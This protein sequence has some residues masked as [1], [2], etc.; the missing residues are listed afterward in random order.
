MPSATSGV[1]VAKLPKVSDVPM[2]EFLPEQQDEDINKVPWYK[3]NLELMDHFDT[4]I[5]SGAKKGH[6]PPILINNLELIDFPANIPEWA[7]AAQLLFLKEVVFLALPS[8]LTVVKLTTDPRIPA[9]YDGLVATVVVDKGKQWAVPTIDDDSD[10][11][12]SQSEEEE[13][14]KEGCIPNGLEVKVWGLL[15]VE[16]L[17]SCFCGALGPCCYYSYLTNTVFIRTNTN[18]V[19]AFK[20][21]S[22]Q[23]A[24]ILGTKVY[25]FAHQGFPGTLYELEQLY[26]YYANLHV[27]RHDRIVAYMLLSKLKDFTQHC[28]MLLHNCTMTLLCLDPSYW[29]LINPMQGPEDLLFTEKCHIPSRFLCVK[30]DGATALHMTRT[31]DL[32]MLFDLKQLAQ[33]FVY[34]MHW[35]TLFGFVLCRALCANSTGKTTLVQWLALVMVHPGLYCEAIDAFNKVYKEQFV[36][37]HGANVTIQQVHVPDDKFYHPTMSLDI[38]CKVDNERLEHLQLYRTL[39]AIPHWDGWGEINKED[40]YCLMFKHAE[41]GT[42]GVFPEANGLYYYIGMDLNVG[43]LWKRTLAH[44]MIGAVTNIVL[45]NCEMVDATV[46]GGPMTPLIMESEPLLSATNVATGESATTREV[47]KIHWVR[48]WAEKPFHCT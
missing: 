13:E 37:Q 15:D 21:S 47:G 20:F 7:E 19:A 46:A 2:M 1:V 48:K 43:Q 30:D 38:F 4:I 24:K 10:Y 42:A 33:Y 45:T 36:P 32:N 9:Q 6:K 18:C 12:Q 41:E 26:K 14:A 3:D 23:S 11:G 29:D 22:G 17:N 34:C 5:P 25:K 35:R 40:H 31:P 39:A 16:R 27:P 28:N 8:K 44:G